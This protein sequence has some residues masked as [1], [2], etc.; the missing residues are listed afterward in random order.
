MTSPIDAVERVL[1]ALRDVD[2]STAV[3]GDDDELLEFIVAVEEVGRSVDA[4]RVQ[5]AVEVEK[6]SDRVFGDEGLSARHGYRTG[7]LLVEQLTGVFSSAVRQRIRVGQLTQSRASVTGVPLPPLFPQVGAELRSGRLCLDAADAITRE[8]R[9]AS[10]RADVVMLADAERNLVAQATGSETGVPLSAD[11]VAGQARLW[12]DALDPDGVE[13]RA[14]EAFQ[15]RGMW[16][17]RTTRHGVHPVGGALTPEVAAQ[18]FTLAGAVATPKSAPK[19]LPT[20]PCTCPGGECVCEDPEVR[21]TRTPEQRGH[22]LFATVLTT[23]AKTTDELSVAGA[24]PTV[25]VTVRAE[26]LLRDEGSGRIVGVTDPVP[27]STVRQQLCDGAVQRAILGPFGKLVALEHDHRLFTRAQ[28]LGIVARDGTTCLIPG[29]GFPA[30]GCEAHHVVEWS[31]DNHT[32][33]D[34][35][36]LVC[37]GH[38]RMLERGQWSIEFIRGK[39]RVRA[40][41]W[42]RRRKYANTG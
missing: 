26:D 14:D 5:A 35:G 41:G 33:T 6:R 42:L 18:W 8:L 28:R 1:A 2:G 23:F 21:D 34:N 9:K 24:S 31:H 29:C 20:E 11:L 39:P 30:I 27:M 32:A 16:V 40:P 22:D 36:V 17:S 15:A 13:P 38:H 12:R 3:R 25:V 7:A 37:Y 10:P 4:L 19:F